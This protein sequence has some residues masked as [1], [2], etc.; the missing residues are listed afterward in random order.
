ME[1]DLAI[2]GAGPAGLSAALYAGR[3]KARTVV[4]EEKMAGG[5]MNVTPVIENYPGFKSVGGLELAKRMREQAESLETVEFVDKEVVDASGSFPAFSL[6]TAD[7]Q[8]FKAKA[9]ILAT[10]AEYRKIGV[11]GGKEFEGRGVVYCA[12]CDAPLFEGKAVAVVGGGNNALNTA[13]MLAD[14]AKK[15]FLVHRR[16]EFRAEQVL[17]DR[18][19][20]KGNTE[21]VL[22]AVP[23]KVIG[24]KMV[25]GLEYEDARTKEKKTLEVEGVFVSIGVTPVSEL[26]KKLGAEVTENNYV[27]TDLRTCATTAKGVFAAGDV[28]GWWRQIIAACA[29]GGVA[30]TNAVEAVRQK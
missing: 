27:K 10:G 1:C 3:R 16:E 14:T 4:F 17:V 28:T 30:A 22:N 19:R 15:V 7:G 6:K 21:F 25:S 29:Q 26:A 9:I 13:L 12:T 8:E 20:K 18:L 23:T 2:V 5:S 11:P 24:K